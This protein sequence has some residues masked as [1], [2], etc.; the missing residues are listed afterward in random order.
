MKVFSLQFLL[1]AKPPSSEMTGNP[2]DSKELSPLGLRE[3][4]VYLLTVLLEKLVLIMS[5]FV[6]KN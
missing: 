3:S 6:I 1:V 5:Y 4:N 2:R